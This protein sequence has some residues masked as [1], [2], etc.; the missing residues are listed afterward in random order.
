MHSKLE[1]EL[2]QKYNGLVAGIDEA[3]RGPWAGPVVAACVILPEKFRLGGLNDS[4]Q[5]TE[6]DRERLY[7]KIKKVAQV[8]C[9][10]SHHDLIDKVGIRRATFLAMQEALSQ[11]S[12]QPQYLLV[13]GRD[14]FPFNIESQFIIQGDA[15]IACI[16]AA[17]IIAKVERDRWM[18]SV[19]KQYPQYEFHSHKGYGTE[20]H[21]QLLQEHGPCQLHRKSYKPVVEILNQQLILFE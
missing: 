12:P 15:K 1:K 20:R 4:K 9:A 6:A 2:K 14:N 13:D 7:D 8:G 11:I 16:A 18:A 21:A 3:G 19:S 5:L 17:S 10:F